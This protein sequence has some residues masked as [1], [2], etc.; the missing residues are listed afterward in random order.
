M[1][2][3]FFG[4]GFLNGFRVLQIKDCFQIEASPKINHHWP[5]K[6]LLHDCFELDIWKKINH[7]FT[8]FIL[9]REK[10]FH[11]LLK[12]WVNWMKKL[13]PTVFLM[14][15]NPEMLL[16][17]CV[18]TCFFLLFNFLLFWVWWFVFVSLLIRLTTAVFIIIRHYLGPWL[19]FPEAVARR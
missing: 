5:S 15:M 11:W 8:Q 13:H 14:K 18:M 19:L 10:S 3:F 9:N 4:F 12:K 7:L 6:K 2:N 17:Q 1:R 16:N